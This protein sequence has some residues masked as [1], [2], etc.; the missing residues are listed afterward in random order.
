MSVPLGIEETLAQVLRRYFGDATVF[1]PIVVFG[2]GVEVAV[3]D[4]CFT[5]TCSYEDRAAVARPAAVRRMDDELDAI[6]VRA[7]ARQ[8]SRC[9][10]CG[11]FRVYEDAHLLAGSNFAHDL[12]V[13]P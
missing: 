8:I 10:F 9:L 13:D 3:H 1:L 6:D 7:G 11:G 12:A 2:P 5:G 4:C